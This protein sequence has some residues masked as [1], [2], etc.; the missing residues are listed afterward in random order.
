M[1]AATLV[2]VFIVVLVSYR[3]RYWVLVG[4]ELI[5]M[6]LREALLASTMVCKVLTRLRGL[7]GSGR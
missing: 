7:Q 3:R 4:A 1:L 6:K 5:V 2:V